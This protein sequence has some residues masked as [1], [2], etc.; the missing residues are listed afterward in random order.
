MFNLSSRIGSLR[1]TAGGRHELVTGRKDG[2][3]ELVAETL[4]TAG[5]K[6]Y[7]LA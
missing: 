7:L 2:L 1:G 6:S 4:T 5:D 3:G